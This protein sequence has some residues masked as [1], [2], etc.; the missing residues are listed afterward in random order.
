MSSAAP[1]VPRDAAAAKAGG[2]ADSA[3]K[4]LGAEASNFVDGVPSGLGAQAALQ[5]REYGPVATKVT[6][7][8]AVQT[9]GGSIHLIDGLTPDRV[10][11]L[12]GRAVPGAQ[13]DLAIIRVVYLDAPMRELWLDQ[14]RGRGVNATADTVLL[15]GPDGGLSLQWPN[16][17]DG[18]LSLSGH[19]TA[20][21]LRILARRVR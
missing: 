9:L 17:P 7:E 4:P 14:Q 3:A 16:G 13:P 10:E 1:L 2:R 6:L 18:W 19:L 15:H 12:S 20:D 11:R 8:E 5:R 21:S